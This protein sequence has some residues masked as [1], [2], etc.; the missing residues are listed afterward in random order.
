M[1]RFSAVFVVALIAGVPGVSTFAQKPAPVAVRNRFLLTIDS[2][3]RGPDL[4]GWPPT[5]LRWSLG[6]LQPRL[7]LFTEETS[8]ADE[9]RRILKLFEDN[10]R[11]GRVPRST[12]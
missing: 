1:R 9:Y 4:V 3:M 2:I 7:H 8:W 12:N 5:A 11:Y 10:L 6:A